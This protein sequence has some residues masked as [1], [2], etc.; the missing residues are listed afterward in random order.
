MLHNAYTDN[1]HTLKTQVTSGGDHDVFASAVPRSVRGSGRVRVTYDE[2]CL[3]TKCQTLKEQGR[4]GRSAVFDGGVM[5]CTNIHIRSHTRVTLN[6]NKFHA[7]FN[8][9]HRN[10]PGES[11]RVCV[12]P[13][14][15]VVCIPTTYILHNYGA[16][17]WEWAFLGQAKKYSSHDRAVFGSQKQLCAQNERV[18]RLRRYSIR[19]YKCIKFAGAKIQR[20][21]TADRIAHRLES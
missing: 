11:L 1:A 13:S 19:R 7:I 9:S 12:R 16:Q 8:F 10:Q 21:Q 2:N 20:F 6:N 18:C 17:A 14:G 5:L 15:P 4:F 3:D